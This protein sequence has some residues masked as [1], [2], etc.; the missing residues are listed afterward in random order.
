MPS[1]K[2]VKKVKRFDSETTINDFIT[3][4]NLENNDII[5]ITPLA[6]MGNIYYVLVYL[7]DPYEIPD[8]TQ[9][10]ESQEKRREEDHE[11]DD[12]GEDE[13]IEEDD[14]KDSI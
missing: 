9:L 2:K 12:I 6:S 14:E 11:L 7:G 4:N 8:D 5:S 1:L 10:E 13:F 3:T